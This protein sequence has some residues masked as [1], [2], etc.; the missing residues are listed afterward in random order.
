MMPNNDSDV[1]GT[2][3][4]RTESEQVVNAQATRNVLEKQFVRWAKLL[5]PTP[6]VENVSRLK[7]R[8]TTAVL[9]TDFERGQEGQALD[10]LGDGFTTVENNDR[11]VTSDAADLLL[12]EG[13]TYRFV[14]FSPTKRYL[15]GA[16]HQSAGGSGGSGGTGGV[17]TFAGRAGAVI[18]VAGDYTPGFI[19]A[20]PASH[21]VDADPH[22]QYELDANKGVASGYASLDGTGKVPASQLP[23]SGSSVPAWVL[24]HPDTPPASPTLFGGV[25]Y[26]LEFGSSSPQ[27]L[28]TRFRMPVT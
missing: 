21:L 19:G 8:N 4:N 9:V 27:G 16:W 18:P 5:D 24:R 3:L 15:D 14:H 1:T 22:P 28:R 10:I 7:F 23:T 13:V 25:N 6:S 20:V 2:G 26:N 12:K 11:I 17:T